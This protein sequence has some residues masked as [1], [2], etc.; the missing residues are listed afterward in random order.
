[1]RIDTDTTTEIADIGD[2]LILT[3]WYGEY[4]ADFDTA[5]THAAYVD[6]VQAAAREIAPDVVVTRSGVVYIYVTDPDAEVARQ[7]DW[8]AL[9]ES[10]DVSAIAVEIVSIHEARLTRAGQDW[11]DARRVEREAARHAL[12]LVGPADA[13][14]VPRAEIARLLRVDRQTVYRA[15]GLKD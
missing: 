12:A 10:V 7:I 6:A 1:M 9:V 15:L 13:A 4:A 8:K 2:L 5:A 3:D 14:G 11:E